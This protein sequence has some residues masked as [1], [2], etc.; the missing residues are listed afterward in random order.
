MHAPL[1]ELY[2]A[3]HRPPEPAAKHSRLLKWHKLHTW[4]LEEPS[5]LCVLL[6]L[7]RI[8]CPW[9]V[10]RLVP[11]TISLLLQ[12]MTWRTIPQARRM[13]ASMVIAQT[14]QTIPCT[15]VTSRQATIAWM[16]AAMARQ[17]QY[18]ILQIREQQLIDSTAC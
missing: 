14:T 15:P 12:R 16:T 8:L 5:P 17:L 6:A 1:T 18:S 4:E 2:S 10:A 11:S 7:W 9:A 3:S 13:T